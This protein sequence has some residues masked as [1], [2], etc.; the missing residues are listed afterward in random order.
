MLPRGE[1]A[2]IIAGLGL[3]AGA[4]DRAIFGVAVLMTLVTTLVAPPA[5][6]ALFRPRGAGRH[7]S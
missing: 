7:R 6:V 3:A 5:L 2:L 1:V 4:I